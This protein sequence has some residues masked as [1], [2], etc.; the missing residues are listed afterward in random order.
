M[1]AQIRQAESTFCSEPG[2]P[3]EPLEETV[4]RV[5]C[6][7]W[8]FVELCTPY[9]TAYEQRG[10]NKKPEVAKMVR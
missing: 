6:K 2:E 4:C 3:L 1:C 5:H 10:A 8:D 9:K 7:A